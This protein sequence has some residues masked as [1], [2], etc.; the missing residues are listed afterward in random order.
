MYEGMLSQEVPIS[1]H[2]RLQH[3]LELAILIVQNNLMILYAYDIELPQEF[4][5]L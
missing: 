4:I 5:I 2:T 3:L 1:I